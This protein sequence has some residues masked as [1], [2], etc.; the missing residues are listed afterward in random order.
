MRGTVWKPAAGSATNTCVVAAKLS[1]MWIKT[2]QPGARFHYVTS[3]LLVGLTVCAPNAISP[4]RR[5]ILTQGASANGKNLINK[6]SIEPYGRNFRGT[7]HI[8]ER[9]AQTARQ[10]GGLESNRRSVDR[11]VQRP[12]PPSHKLILTKSTW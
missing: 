2:A 7:G 9:L 10:C 3:R 1:T 5:K 6:I 11:Q 12:T 4:Q 8:C